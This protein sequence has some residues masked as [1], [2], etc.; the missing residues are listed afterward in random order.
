VRC[1]DFIGANQT[2]DD[3]LLRCRGT[4]GD[5]FGSLALDDRALSPNRA[6]ALLHQ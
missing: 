1:A 5:T 3:A 6:I 4:P 2:L